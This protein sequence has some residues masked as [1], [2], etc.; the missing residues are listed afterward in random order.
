MDFIKY[1]DGGFSVIEN[2]EVSGAREGKYGV[3]IIVSRNSTAS[4]VFTSNKVVAAPLLTV[5][6]PI[7]LQA[8]R[9]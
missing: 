6:M 5:V 1:L 4:A 7:V 3:T 2:L 8:N 9:D